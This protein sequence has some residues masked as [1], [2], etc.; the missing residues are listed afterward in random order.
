M[1]NGSEKVCPAVNRQSTRQDGLPMERWEWLAST[2][3]V[4][5]VVHCTVKKSAGKAKT[6][7]S[8][9]LSMSN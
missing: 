5:L 4:F 1:H 3:P 8:E 9:S 6:V 2:S 7:K